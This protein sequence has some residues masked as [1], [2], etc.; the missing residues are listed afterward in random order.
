MVVALR[1]DLGKSQLHL[2]FLLLR[3]SN[4]NEPASFSCGRLKNAR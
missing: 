3:E 2:L 1:A 4:L